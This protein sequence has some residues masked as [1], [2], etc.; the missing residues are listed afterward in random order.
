MTADPIRDSQQNLTGRLDQIM[1]R[2]DGIETWLSS[3][4]D[5]HRPP[6]R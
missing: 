2:L 5:Q 1:E 6:V 3:E 4:A